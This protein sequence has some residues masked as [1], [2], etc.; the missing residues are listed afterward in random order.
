MS[1]AGN[2]AHNQ[3]IAGA[4]TELTDADISLLCDIGASFSSAPSAEKRARLERLIEGGFIEAASANMTPARYQ[5]TAK[6]QRI[7]TERG[8]GLNEA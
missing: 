1:P 4:D 6:A 8:V 5:L 3:A 2:D 7:L